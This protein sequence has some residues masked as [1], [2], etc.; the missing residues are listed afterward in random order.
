MTF[1]GLA[2]W[3]LCAHPDPNGGARHVGRHAP[4]ASGDGRTAPHM[5][6]RHPDNPR[7]PAPTSNHPEHPLGGPSSQEDAE[8][9][10]PGTRGRGSSPAA[11]IGAGGDSGRAAGPAGVD[12]DVVSPPRPAWALL[13][14]VDA[15]LPQTF[16][17]T[18]VLF[19]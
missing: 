7:T 1:G 13:M 16:A 8:T 5:A 19:L 12:H 9:R 2:A 11:A 18:V 15:A 14:F 3:Q 6:A 4:S 10:C 17:A